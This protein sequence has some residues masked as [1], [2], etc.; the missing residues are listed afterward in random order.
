MDEGEGREWR[1]KFV[2]MDLASGGTANK[3][4][5]ESIIHEMTTIQ[6]YKFSTDIL[7]TKTVIDSYEI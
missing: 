6:T 7:V 3:N 1:Q 4:N 5:N 2:S